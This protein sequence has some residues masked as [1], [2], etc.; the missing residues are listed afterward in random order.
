MPE[1]DTNLLDVKLLV[2]AKDFSP[3]NLFLQGI[4]ISGEGELRASIQSTPQKPILI[5]IH[6]LLKMAIFLVQ[7]IMRK[8]PLSYYT[9]L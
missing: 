9:V 7:I 5:L 6:Y 8:A 4:Q 2:K 1:M 3:L